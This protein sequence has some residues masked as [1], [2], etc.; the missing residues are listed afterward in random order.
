[1]TRMTIRLLV[2]VAVMVLASFPAHAFARWQA[3]ADPQTI[4][5]TVMQ[6]G[7]ALNGACSSFESDIVFDPDDMTGAQVTVTI[8]TGSC[9]T[10][11]SEKDAYLPQDVWFDV[12]GFPR[13]T[14]EASSFEVLG[15]GQY[16]AHGKL[17]LKGVTQSLDLPF[18]LAIS[19]DE[20]HV[21]GQALLPRLDFGIGSGPQ[22]SAAS[23]VGL[24]VT[25]HIDLKAKRK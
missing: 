1:M 23:V 8:D 19:G 21:T 25:V 2:P 18:T 6:G 13:A 3:V 4:T 24:D 5:W 10:G 16:I 11:D 9:R 14:Y 22:L 7:K 20:A 12:P 17:T 15:G